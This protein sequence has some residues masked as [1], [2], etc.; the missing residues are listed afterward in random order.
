[1]GF[2]FSCNSYGFLI[3]QVLYSLVHYPTR[4]LQIHGVYAWHSGTS[5]RILELSHILCLSGG[6]HTY[7]LTN[8]HLVAI[9]LFTCSH[10]LVVAGYYYYHHLSDNQ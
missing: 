4:D 2:K 9:C 8:L 3:V 5:V 1:M 7:L 6:Y 10:G